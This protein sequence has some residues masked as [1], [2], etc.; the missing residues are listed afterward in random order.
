M[1]L[2]W[3]VGEWISSS[4]ILSLLFYRNRTITVPH[5][6]ILTS[7]NSN[8]RKVNILLEAL[9]RA[10][11]QVDYFALDLS[12]PEL[13][14]TFAEVETSKFKYVK[15][16]GFHGTYDDGLAWLSRPEHQDRVNCVMSLGSSI[17]NFSRTEAAQFLAS[18]SR[19]L[20][21]AD[22]VIIGIDGTTDKNRIF[23]AYNDSQGVTEQFYR[24]GL[25]HANGVLG[26]KAFKQNDWAVLGEY[27]EEENKHLA[28]YVAL[29]DV[30]IDSVLIKEGERIPFEHA[31][32]YTVEQSD[33]L[34]HDSALV[35]KAV[36]KD[37]T[38]NHSKLCI[39]LAPEFSDPYR[40][41]HIEA[42]FDPF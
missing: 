13:Q 3:A 23:T 26:Y 21:P 34:W 28:S 9:E 18:F 37:S 27:V 41:L 40:S 16:N 33:S 10:Q 15:F 14:R 17:G 1:S 20:R 12:Y 25:D 42:L 35:P 32:K 11:K 6:Q 36:Y 24:N 2:S 19:A 30:E 7:V 29:R 8:L 4:V 31:Y 39:P 38:G 22:L 5:G